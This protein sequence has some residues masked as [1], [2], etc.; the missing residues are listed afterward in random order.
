MA[1]R[2]IFEFT[3]R[4]RFIILNEELWFKKKLRFNSIF[5]KNYYLALKFKHIV[6]YLTIKLSIVMKKLMSLLVAVALVAFMTSCGGAEETAQDQVQQEVVQQ[7]VVQQEVPVEAPAQGEEA[8]Q[9]ESE[10]AE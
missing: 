3:V 9:T 10:E 8:T 7:E 6:N 4:L 1:Y 5:V 2:V